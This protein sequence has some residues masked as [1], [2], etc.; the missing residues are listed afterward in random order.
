MSLQNLKGEKEGEPKM[1][2]VEWVTLSVCNLAV[3]N[4][5]THALVDGIAIRGRKPLATST[6]DGAG[7]GAGTALTTDAIC[8]GA[9]TALSCAWPGVIFL[10]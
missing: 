6:V 4:M 3:M 7:A 2:Q 9:G 1:Q 10:A 8:V 5:R